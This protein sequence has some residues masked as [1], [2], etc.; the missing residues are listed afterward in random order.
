MKALLSF[1]TVLPVRRASLQ[2]AAREVR[3]LP[4]LVCYGIARSRLLLAA[5]MVPPGVAATLALGP[6][7]SPP[8]C[9][10][11][12][13]SR[14][15]RRLMAHG[16]LDR[17]REVLRDTRVGIGGLGAL[18]LVYAPTVAPSL[19]CAPRLQAV[20]RSPCSPVRSR[21][22][23]R[24]SSCWS[25]V[26]PQICVP[27]PYPLYER[28]RATPYSRRH[29]CVACAAAIPSGDERPSSAARRPGYPCRARSPTDLRSEVRWDRRR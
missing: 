15:G 29:R 20:Q 25:S 13:A 4:L 1:F 16:G 22:G 27:P 5:H 9:T 14:R 2:E 24:C 23:R 18:F 26:S 17:R 7:F 28:F 3:L 12:T 19:R 8:V 6:C 21:P 10:T 11:P